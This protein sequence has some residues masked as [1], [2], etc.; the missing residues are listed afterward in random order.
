MDLELYFDPAIC[1]FAQQKLLEEPGGK[2][3]S[4]NVL[5]S[6]NSE[7]HNRAFKLKEDPQGMVHTCVSV[8]IHVALGSAPE[9]PSSG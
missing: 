4:T 3:G 1:N 9:S 6:L 5:L 8:Y 7:I 2:A